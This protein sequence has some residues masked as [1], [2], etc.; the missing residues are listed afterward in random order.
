MTLLLQYPELREFQKEIDSEYF[1]HTENREIFLAW[2][3]VADSQKLKDE[4]DPALREH[5]DV[6]INK[7][8]PINRISVEDRLNACIM[9]LRKTYLRNLAVQRG[10]TAAAEPD[11]SYFEENVE[12]ENKLRNLNET[13]I[14]KRQ[15]SYGK[16]RR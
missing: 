7:E 12:I 10:E 9:E 3:Q 16:L 2:Q 4:V 15:S 8:L 6:I 14:K 1:T 5:L 11:I 13:R